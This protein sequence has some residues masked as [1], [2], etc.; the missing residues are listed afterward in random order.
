MF[1]DI[2]HSKP[3]VHPEWSKDASCP[4]AAPISPSLHAD[5]HNDLEDTYASNTFRL[6]AYESLGGAVRIPTEAYDD[7]KAPG[8]DP[9]WDIFVK[10]HEYLEQRFPL[11]HTTLQ[12]TTVNTYA[13][14]YHWQGSDLSLK[15]IL[16]TA[17]QDVV[18]IDPSTRHQWLQP[19]YSGLYDGKWIWG[20]GSCDDK[21]GLVGSLTAVESLLEKGFQPK[22]SVVLAYGIDEERGG[23]QGGPPIRDHLLATYGENAFSILIDEGGELDV[24]DD[25]VIASPAVAEKG[26]FDLRLTVNTIGG[27]SS[28][29]PKHTSI[30]I[31][32][33]LIV[34]LENH[35]HTPH[36]NRNDTYYTN[37]Q[38]QA[39]YDPD[40]N[41]DLRS[42]IKESLKSDHAL[43]NLEA[44][45][46]E[47]DRRLVAIGSTTQA[48]DLISGGVKVNALPEEASAVVNH[49]IAG[50][51]SV[52]AVQTRIVEVLLP[53]AKKYNIS[54]DAF[55]EE[56]D[57][58][59]DD[60]DDD[61]GL[62]RAYAGRVTLSD[63]FGTAL[64]PAPIT[65]TSKNPAYEFI[66][67]TIIAV[68]KTSAKGKGSDKPVVVAPGF[69]IGNTDTRF[70]WK[71]TKNIFRYGHVDKYARYNGAHTVNEALEAE[72]FIELIR[73]FTTI[74]LNADETKLL[75]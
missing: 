24:R 45:L 74:I 32:A 10:L 38:C 2:Q 3:T 40:L 42:A 27:H 37:L 75:E 66:S 41:E 22:R 20:R 23:L 47:S 28:V 35:P 25:V 9:R 60:D 8:Q 17:H 1:V 62:S 21:P 18:P 30:G 26:H 50:Y 31:L 70:Y 5:L 13:L 34:Q 73:F 65:P 54:I 67:G 43:K 71:L 33:G 69:L 58:S 19:P 36:L 14:V 63:A 4:Q 61:E 51:S 44:Q 15:P 48:V 64:E 16:L 53:A 11:V 72:A 57:P 29:P 6:E 39:A 7:L 59:D 52:S 55:G 46:F 56:V 68:S 12:K 49:R